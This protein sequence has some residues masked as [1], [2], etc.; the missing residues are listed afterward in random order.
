MIRS[1][2]VVALLL[3]AACA[4]SS[5]QPSQAESAQAM[6]SGGDGSV[7]QN[8]ASGDSAAIKDID[9]PDAP[10]TPTEEMP[11]VQAGQPGVVC[12]KVVK[13]GSI[14]PTTVCRR[15]AD[16]ERRGDSDRRLYEDIKRNT[17]L[18]ADG[19]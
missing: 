19:I 8:A 12:E 14:M 15:K 18:G 5:T 1:L 4:T 16:I 10:K 3:I 13:T 11:H 9:A 7:G 17:T 6:N 2:P